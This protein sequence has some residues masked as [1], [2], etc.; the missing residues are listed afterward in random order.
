M[1]YKMNG[2]LKHFGL[3]CLLLLLQL[4]LRAESVKR[5]ENPSPPEEKK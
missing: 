3:F 1:A 2:A 5:P 4:L